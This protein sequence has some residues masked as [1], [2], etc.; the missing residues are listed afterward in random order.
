MLKRALKWAG[1]EPGAAASSDAPAALRTEQ[2]VFAALARPVD[3]ALEASR[4]GNA[5]EAAY[6]EQADRYVH[7]W[8]HYLAIYD[9]Y[10]ARY[11]G[12][13]VRL[14]EIGVYN[15]GSLQVWR[16]YLGAQAVIHGL[17][18]DPR[19]ALIDDPDLRIH[20][21]SQDDVELLGR[22]VAEM[23]GVDVVIDDGSHAWRH[24][25]ATF[26]ALYP[27]LAPDGVYMCEDVHTSYW[28]LSGEGRP[29]AQSFIDYAKTLVDRLHV[30]YSLGEQSAADMAFALMTGGIGFHDS[31]VVIEK[32]VRSPPHHGVVGH[33][34]VI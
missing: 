12:K 5:V 30:W 28:P 4:A 13:P 10:L 20:I 34:T 3:Q 24:Q 31:M 6:Y 21:G 9:R 23:G 2:D 29:D 26:E 16:R 11:R 19:C 14:L 17:D 27:T 32:Q 15:G 25:I 8:H 7:K 33:R 18:L 1:V 22:I